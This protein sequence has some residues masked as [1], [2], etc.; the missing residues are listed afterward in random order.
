MSLHRP[1]DIFHI[2]FSVSPGGIFQAHDVIEDK[3]VKAVVVSSLDPV[4]FVL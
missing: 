4:G 3:R 2:D 1:F